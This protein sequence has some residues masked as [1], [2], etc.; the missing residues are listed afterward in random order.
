MGKM[1][2]SLVM[3]TLGSLGDLYPYLAVA[4]EL[5]K[6]GHEVTIATNE[7]YRA[8]IKAE[9]LCFHSL[10]PDLAPLFRDPEV[11]R[12]GLD[13]AAG[14]E[15]IVR[16]LLLP[17]LDESYED[18]LKASQGKDLLVSHISAFALPLVAEKLRLPWISIA[19]YPLAFSSSYDP[20]ALPTN[21]N[22]ARTHQLRKW[23]FAL[24]LG[25]TKRQ[26]RVWMKPVDELRSR[27]GLA[28][29]AQHPLFEGK[30][31]PYA[32][33]AWFS[34]LL[35][36]PQPDW[37]PNTR[38][39][40]FPFYDRQETHHSLDSRLSE[41]LE[42]GEPPVVFTLGTAVVLGAGDFFEQSVSAVRRMGCR[43]V[44][45]GGAQSPSRVGI[46]LPET[47]FE[48]DYAPL[49][50]LLPRA[51]A[52]VHHGGIGTTAQA[53]RAGCPSLIVPFVYDQPDNA[54]RAA[55]LGVARVLD[56]ELYTAKRA[57]AE[58]MRLLSDGSSSAR[59]VEI[60]QEVRKED[61]V[62][63]ACDG[64]EEIMGAA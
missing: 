49:S 34:R 44:L 45:L 31:S 51:I 16:Q 42:K 23:E 2:K 1:G 60:G 58:L 8:Q 48:T 12:Q 5:R 21:T 9:G 56:R 3:A 20:C 4:I 11:I 54:R 7:M 52:A 63:A 10:R 25:Y 6:R 62:A 14:T 50:A 35:T 24:L 43:A 53:L 59:A 61:G 46:R 33:L 47:I 57:Q 55:K 37:P 40:G 64:L 13:V 18:L 26:T 38:I 36:P 30:F 29:A 27:L 41:F 32:S 28:P 19:L 22:L 39:T 17:N 15:Y